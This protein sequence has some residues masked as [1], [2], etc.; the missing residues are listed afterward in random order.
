[1]QQDPLKQLNELFSSQDG[2]MIESVKHALKYSLQIAPHQQR[3]LH[4]I[5]AWVKYLKRMGRNQE[6]EAYQSLYDRYLELKQYQGSDMFVMALFKYLSLHEYVGK[7][8]DLNASK[9]I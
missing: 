8:F 6:A 2:G 3:A 1:M 5:D 7:G 4:A 9:K